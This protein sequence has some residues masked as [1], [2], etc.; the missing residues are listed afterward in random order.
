MTI[1]AP[2]SRRRR[3][4]RVTLVILLV[5]A[6]VALLL[7]ALLSWVVYDTLS[8]APRACHPS[9]QANTPA[10][11]QVGAGIDSEPYLMPDYQE[12]RFASRDPSI[13]DAELAAWWIPQD[14]A[15]SPAVVLVHG[16]QSCRREATVLLAAG[17]LH[18]AGFSVFLMDLRDHGDSQG[19]DARFAAGSEEYLDVLGGWDWVRGQGVQEQKIGIVG[20]SFGSLNAVV[21]G[22]EDPAVAAVWVDSAPPRTADGIGDFLVDQLRQKI[23]DVAVAARILVPGTV[24]W[25]KLIAGDD[26]LRFDAIDEVARY[27]GRSIAFVHGAED[28][29]LPA[30]YATEL[31][32]AAAAAGAITPDAWIVPGAGHTQAI[33]VDPAGYER[34]IVAFFTAALG[35]PPG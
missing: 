6:V 28:A 14:A 32:D 34:R 29:V 18:R 35:T 17:M 13:P 5:L 33:F 21:A 24:V 11:F 15:D 20:F 2:R 19:D 9:D 3:W 1:A 16:I 10:A 12:V 8:L 22:A 26:L 31:H 30:R 27:G 23:G 4:L 25:A 7:Y